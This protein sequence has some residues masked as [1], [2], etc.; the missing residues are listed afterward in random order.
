MTELEDFTVAELHDQAKELDIKGQSTL[1]KADLV[2]A[3]RAR[4]EPTVPPVVGDNYVHPDKPH[5][6]LNDQTTAEQIQSMRDSVN[7]LG[8]QIYALEQRLKEGI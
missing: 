2:A 3:I 7:N 4:T 6:Y 5:T 8:T 1:N